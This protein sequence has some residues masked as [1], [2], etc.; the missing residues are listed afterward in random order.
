MADWLLKTSIDSHLI[1]TLA[2]LADSIRDD[3]Y[4]L[5]HLTSDSIN[6]IEQLD[7]HLFVECLFTLSL[8]R[9]SWLTA[10]ICL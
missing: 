4:A 9:R 3:R 1:E 5:K 6:N 7:K 8:S 2:E 10:N